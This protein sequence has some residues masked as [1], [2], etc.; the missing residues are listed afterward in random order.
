MRW[1]T[2]KND[3]RSRI[4]TTPVSVVVANSRP[5]PN[6]TAHEEQE[7]LNHVFETSK[8]VHPQVQ[9]EVGNSTGPDIPLK[10]SLH[11]CRS[12]RVMLDSF[13]LD[14]LAAMKDILTETFG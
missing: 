5:Y 10:F 8:V 3:P 6:T 13:V 2:R 14:S 7:Q 4:P 11:F 12:S 9:A 1:A